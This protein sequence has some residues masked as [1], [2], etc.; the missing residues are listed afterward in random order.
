[1]TVNIYYQTEKE[2][3][4]QKFLFQRGY[5]RYSMPKG[6]RVVVYH[7]KYVWGSENKQWDYHG[8]WDTI[9][10]ATAEIRRNVQRGAFER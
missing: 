2:I 3:S 9:R 6:V 4:G 7:W 1:V 10:E 5:D 8:T